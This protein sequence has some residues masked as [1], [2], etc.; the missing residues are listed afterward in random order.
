[1]VDITYQKNAVDNLV[2]GFKE[3]LVA[4][5]EKAKMVFK[6]P[7]GSGKTVMVAQMLDRIKDEPLEEECVFIW[8]SMGELAHQSYEKLAYQYLPDSEYSMI[9]INDI[10]SEALKTNTILFCNW[11]KMNSTT[12]EKNGDGNEIELFSNVFVRLNESGRNLQNVLEKTRNED[13]KIILIVDEAHHTYLGP[14]SQKLVDKVIMPDLTIEVS[15]TPIFKVSAKE[16]QENVGRWVEVE[17]ADVRESGLIKKGVVINSELSGV[18]DKTSTNTVVL[19]AALKQRKLLLEKYKEEGANVNPLILIQLPSEATNEMSEL[20]ATTCEMV[21][22]FM[23][24]HDITFDNGKLAIWVSGNHI[25]KDVKTVATPND[26]PI[27]VLIFKQAIAT[28]WDCPRADILVMLRDIKSVIFELQ[29]VG[30]IMRMPEPEREEHY[31]EP[32][33]NQAYVYT[34]ISDIAFCEDDDTRT[35]YKVSSNTRIELF[36]DDFSWPNQYRKRVVGQRHRLNQLFRP[37]FLPMM[38]KKFKIEKEDDI[39]TRRHKVDELLE[40]YNEELKVPILSDVAFEHLDTVDQTIFENSKRICFDADKPFIERTFNYFLKSATS[41]FAPHDSSRV[42]KTAI[43]KWFSDNGFDDEEEIQRI[44][45][46]SIENQK[47]LQKVV[48][49]AKEEFKKTLDKETEIVKSSFSI[50][51]GREYGDNYELINTTK[52]VL[53][54][55]YRIK[56]CWKTEVAFEK[57]LDESNDVVWWFRNGEGEPKY[58][59]TMYTYIDKYDN[60]VEALFY[61]D[62]IVKFKDGTFGIFDTKAGDTL[63]PAKEAGKY[64]DLKANSL[65]ELIKKYDEYKVNWEEQGIHISEPIGLWGGIVNVKNDVFFLQADG[66]TQEM[67]LAKAKGKEVDIPKTD[68]DMNSWIS[69]II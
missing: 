41:P 19:A 18:V 42:L 60:E 51:E 15:A 37:I 48:E 61:P 35:Y 11:E 9:E 34:N 8:A 29:T 49:E 1:M 65:Q 14:N 53:Q 17:L 68:Y 28:G 59:C 63:N 50:P 24:E 7:T 30:R 36:E 54:P 39:D 52:H 55:Y 2:K 20:D 66:V 44:V 58:F 13:K 45:A 25:P 67:A 23:R 6:A 57:A 21:E 5:K 31:S 27:E 32:V 62:Y 33:L 26:S 69:L 64:V 12:R 38:D 10:G 47:F 43:Y 4:E 46:C 3:L 22:N 40:I 16:V 56:D